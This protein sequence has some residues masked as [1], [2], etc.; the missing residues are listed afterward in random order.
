M[1]LCTSRRP[2]LCGGRAV[3]KVWC[4]YM[5]AV[6]AGEGGGVCK[7]VA[8]GRGFP[9]ERRV[10]HCH[11]RCPPNAQVRLVRVSSPCS[12]IPSKAENAIRLMSST[13]RVRV[14]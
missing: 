8:V 1:R 10:R 2:R 4:T 3:K 11:G 6:A 9:D 5:G 12:P 7:N 13:K 14:G